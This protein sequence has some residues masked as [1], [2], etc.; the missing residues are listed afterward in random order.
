MVTY[1]VNNTELINKTIG[2][3][4]CTPPSMILFKNTEGFWSTMTLEADKIVAMVMQKTN[5]AGLRMIVGKPII[6]P[7]IKNPMAAI[8]KY[9]AWITRARNAADKG[10]EYKIQ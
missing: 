8:I 2:W 5:F 7:K 10:P 1:K 9:T 6:M 4:F 3:E